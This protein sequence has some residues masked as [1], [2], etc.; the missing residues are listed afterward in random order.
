MKTPAR[1]P[2]YLPPALRRALADGERRLSPCGDGHMVWHSWG[3]AERPTLVLLHGG[4]GSWLHWVRNL[5]ALRDAGYRLLVPDLPGFGDSQAI[6][7]DADSLPAPL[8][9]GLHLL[10]PHDEVSLVGF[11]FGGLTSALWLQAFPFDARRLVLVGAPGLG[12]NTPERIPLK[13]WRHLSDPAAQ[14]QA[15]RHNLLALMLHDADKLDALAL[16]LH[17]DNVTRDRMPRRRLA[18]TDVLARTLPLLQQPL[19]AIYGAHDALYRERL[20]EVRD[21]LQRLAPGGCAW[22][23]V[24]QAGH[25]VQYEAPEAFHAA[26]LSALAT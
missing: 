6:G 24:P 16:D 3:S 17:R 14:D 26:L 2:D 9:E 4:S 15:H 23:E 10:C 11:S 8:H 5:V 12:L 19:A 20:P 7:P 18:S 1:W 25:W 22:H 21:A 13:G